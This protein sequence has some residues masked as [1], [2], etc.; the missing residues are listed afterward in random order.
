MILQLHFIHRVALASRQRKGPFL[1]FESSSHLSTTHGEGFTLSLL[2]LIVKHESC[3][4][5][6]LCKFIILHVDI[7][8]NSK[9]QQQK[10]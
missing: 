7:R 4:Y 9:K 10:R 8:H 5:Q 6:F 3:E 1:A 2:L